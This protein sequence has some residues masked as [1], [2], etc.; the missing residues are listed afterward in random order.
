MRKLIY[1]MGVSL[2]GLIAGS[3]R[4]ID[5]SAP[6]SCTGSIKRGRAAS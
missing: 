5:W 2:D 3:D 6:E 1:S 4:E